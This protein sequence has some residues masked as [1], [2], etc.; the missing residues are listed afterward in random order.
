MTDSNEILKT[1]EKDKEALYQEI[2]WSK[3]DFAKNLARCLSGRKKNKSLEKEI[4]E[5]IIW[6]L[7]AFLDKPNR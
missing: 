5:E 4:I 7:E 3:F 2:I 6:Q 1:E